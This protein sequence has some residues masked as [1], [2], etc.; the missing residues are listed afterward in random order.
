MDRYWIETSYVYGDYSVAKW[1]LHKVTE[2]D[3]EETDEIIVW[4]V[5]EDTP[6][7]TEDDTD[8]GWKAIDD[9]ITEEIGFLP[10]YEVN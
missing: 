7:Y 4:R 2:K 3:G 10:E 1:A 8:A 5:Y 6:G 9:Y